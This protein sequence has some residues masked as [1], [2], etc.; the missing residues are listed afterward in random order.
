MTRTK[1]YLRRTIR[2]APL[3]GIIF[4]SSSGG[5]YGTETL[6]SSSGAG[7][8]MV[9]LAVVP[10]LLSVP[11]SLMNAEL[12]SALPLEGGFYS[13][14][15]IACG[16]FWGFLEAMFSWLA[17]WLDTALYPVIFVDYLS[18][19][20]PDLAR[21]KHSL[22]S[23]WNGGFDIDLH[24]AVAILMMIP[25]AYLNIRGA[26]IIGRTLVAFMFIIFTPIV[27]F[28]VLAVF[29]YSSH[30]NIH[31]MSPFT[32]SGQSLWGSAGA[33][34]GIVLWSYIGY[35]SVT[36]T[37]GEIKDPS[38]NYPMALLITVPL[39]AVTYIVTFFA[40]LASGLYNGHPDKWNN[41][42][43]AIAG[44][45]LGGHWLKNFMIIGGLVA[46][47][48]LF[49]S[50]L[51]CMSR[52]PFVLAADRYLPRKV[53]DISP[54]YGTPVRAIIISVMIYSVFAALNFTTLIDSDMILTLFALML[55][56]VALL[57]LRAKYPN[58][59][60]PFRIGGGWWGAIA[61]CVG[62]VLLTIWLL[63]ST[64]VDEPLAFWIGIIFSV[65]GAIAYPLLKKY[66]KRGELDA[67]LDVSGVDFGDG[68]VPD[69]PR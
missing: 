16:P 12:G 21:G 54:K 18:L 57:V 1:L 55:E 28:T 46:Q 35:D 6:L 33:G 7:M 41:G 2:L 11:M 62:P 22:I 52:L 66:L 39:V 36:T 23:L 53:A 5:P 30:S 43:F 32:L 29:H 60:R 67:E 38:R 48:G 63:Q 4:F 10:L 40:A 47:A 20:F 3:V 24:W 49:S 17:S 45:A 65:G 56:F 69:P 14:V 27:I 19:W 64:F 42:D 9:L 25:I 51:L 58:M 59:K 61:V 15:K 8:S 31:I 26:E 50:F 68:L 44:D 37:G 34:L 13:W